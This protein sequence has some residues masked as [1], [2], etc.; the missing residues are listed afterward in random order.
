MNRSK[1]EIKERRGKIGCIIAISLPLILFGGYYFWIIS[2]FKQLGESIK[3]TRDKSSERRKIK[4]KE[5]EVEFIYKEILVKNKSGTFTGIKKED[6]KIFT[7]AL[8]IQAID[9]FSIKYRIESLINWKSKPN[10]EGIAN[11]DYESIGNRNWQIKDREGNLKSAFRFIE[12]KPDCQI[13]ILISK[14]ELN[15]SISIVKEICKTESIE[16][17]PTMNF[18]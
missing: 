6:E 15:Q 1:N 9:S 2:S 5:K 7:T 18:K 14:E 4:Q 10:I 3:E 8:Q 13:E 11:L 12:D 16:L 17:T